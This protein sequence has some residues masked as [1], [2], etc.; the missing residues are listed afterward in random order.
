MNI[1]ILIIFSLVMG[2][3]PFIIQYLLQL[4]GKLF[5]DVIED[6]IT[7]REYFIGWLIFSLFLLLF[8]GIVFY[9]NIPSDLPTFIIIIIISI[10][11]SFLYSYYFIIQPIILLYSNSSSPSPKWE[12]WLHKEYNVKIK[13]RIIQKEL[14][15]AYAMGV[16]P[17]SKIILVGQQLIDKLP[18]E[19]VKAIILHEVGHTKYRH[20]LIFYLISLLFGVLYVSSLYYLMPIYRPSVY[21]FALV[22]LHGGVFGLIYWLLS[23]IQRKFEYSADLFAATHIGVEKFRIALESLYNMR[24]NKKEPSWVINY[25]SLDQRIKYVKENV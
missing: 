20:T 19:S 7:I 9:S 22:G 8:N 10:P 17:F 24:W 13:V 12:K 4:F 14:I 6:I 18:E 1:L 5:G 25:P 23:V 3:I 21:H 11:I 15:N 16:I 2:A